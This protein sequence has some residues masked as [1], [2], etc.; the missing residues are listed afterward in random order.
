MSLCALPKGSLNAPLQCLTLYLRFSAYGRNEFI[1][2]R[3]EHICSFHADISLNTQMWS[4]ALCYSADQYQKS[5]TVKSERLTFP[6]R[7]EYFED[8][9]V[10]LCMLLWK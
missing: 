8:R 10:V 6:R 5:L 1:G 7:N 3:E 9:F 4:M 2:Q